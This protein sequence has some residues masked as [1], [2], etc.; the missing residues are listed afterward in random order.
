MTDEGYGEGVVQIRIDP[1]W[2][3]PDRDGEVW[4]PGKHLRGLLHLS[5][6]DESD[7]YVVFTDEYGGYLAAPLE[8]TE[9]LG[10]APR[11]LGSRWLTQGAIRMAFAEERRIVWFTR[12]PQF[13]VTHEPEFEG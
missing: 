1:V 9:Y 2:V 11:A 13:V 6:I 8:D 4:L 5:L 10:D 3:Y 12:V 7:M